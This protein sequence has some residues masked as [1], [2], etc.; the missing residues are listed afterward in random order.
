M[1]TTNRTAS[2]F[3]TRVQVKLLASKHSD[4]VGPSL[5]STHT[6]AIVPTCTRGEEMEES[7]FAT[8]QDLVV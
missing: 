7:L 6:V 5:V 8:K 1:Q 4:K 3:S 2:P